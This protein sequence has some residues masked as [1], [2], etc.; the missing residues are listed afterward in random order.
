MVTCP[1]GIMKAKE[2]IPPLRRLQDV[3]WQ[4]RGSNSFKEA[5]TETFLALV[6]SSWRP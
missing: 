3:Q 5:S 1:L 2:A 4:T 6:T